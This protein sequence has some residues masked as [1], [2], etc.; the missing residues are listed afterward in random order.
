MK[1]EFPYSFRLLQHKILQPWQLQNTWSA[2]FSSCKHKYSHKQQLCTTQTSL[3]NQN[4]YVVFIIKTIN[5]VFFPFPHGVHGPLSVFFFPFLLH[6]KSRTLSLCPTEESW[7]AIFVMSLWFFK[8]PTF[9]SFSFLFLFLPVFNSSPKRII[10]LFFC[11][12]FVDL[13]V[14]GPC[15]SWHFQLFQALRSITLEPQHVFWCI[16][17]HPNMH[18]HVYSNGYYIIYLRSKGMRNLKK[19]E[20]LDKNKE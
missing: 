11:W 5:F 16:F 4:Q 9:H 10:Y 1:F 19:I 12:K 18:I 3:K 14:S 13:D 20:I 17:P 2:F 8:Q 15:L 7:K 6:H